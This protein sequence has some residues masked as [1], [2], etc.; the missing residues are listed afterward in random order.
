MPLLII[1]KKLIGSHFLL[2]SVAALLLVGAV[3]AQ[4]PTPS[5]VRQGLMVSEVFH[6]SSPHNPG[7]LSSYV[8]ITNL[9]PINP[10][11]LVGASIQVGRPGQTPATF[12]LPTLTLGPYS[13]TA[14]TGTMSFFNPNSGTFPTVLPGNLAIPAAALFANPLHGAPGQPTFV[15]MT[16]FVPG[17]TVRT[18]AVALNWPAAV[19]VPCGSFTGS[20]TNNTGLALR[21]YR[22]DSDTFLDFFSLPFPV[23]PVDPPYNGP[24]PGASPGRINPE[25][26]RTTAMFFGSSSST[27]GSP[28]ITF[29]SPGI[30][31]VA[32]ARVV[33]GANSLGV[34][35]PV[36][37][38][39]PGGVGFLEFGEHPY[40]LFRRVNNPIFDPVLAGA[41][42]S[43]QTAISGEGA[44]LA[45]DTSLPPGTNPVAPGML[46]S[47]RVPDPFGQNDGILTINMG[48]LDQVSLGLSL[49][50]PTPT[51]TPSGANLRIAR[52]LSDLTTD[53]TASGTGILSK[54]Q[55]D[56]LPPSEPPGDV[57]CEVIVYDL[58]GFSYRAKAR[59]WPPDVNQCGAPALALGSNAVG[60]LDVI[61]LC[62]D[63]SDPKELYILP[64]QSLAT[65]TGSG[66]FFGLIPDLS[67]FGFLAAPLGV[68]PAHVQV[69]SDGVY[70][71]SLT[72]PALSGLNFD[73]AAV[74][75]DPTPGQGFSPFSSAQV[76]TITIL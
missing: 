16:W 71:W 13:R 48:P 3:C 30:P 49:Y 56:L 6:D 35:V 26:S 7:N 64:S 10:I 31:V 65:P 58:N 50:N 51:I 73:V 24:T 32:G 17:G 14:S 41:V 54:V 34:T 46:W 72:S 52:T 19:S 69:N 5:N 2:A 44:F 59:N 47:L 74:E 18:D 68:N 60:N 43:M 33:S 45:Y 76:A 38:N 61:A 40:S 25:M 27:V 11:T 55:L 53:S 21:H 20:V 4:G 1:P 66:P 57:W 67:T 37:V 39:Q 63:P 9:D 28:G 42:L 75:F 15:C 62:F 29:T 22:V 8:E 12:N 36:T 23:P 70:F